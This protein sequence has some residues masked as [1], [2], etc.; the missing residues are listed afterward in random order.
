[1]PTE[2]LCDRDRN[3]RSH[4]LKTPHPAAIIPRNQKQAQAFILKLLSSKQQERGHAATSRSQ[5]GT[6]VRAVHGAAYAKRSAQMPAQRT[7]AAGR[8]DRHRLFGLLVYVLYHKYCTTKT[9]AR[10][11]WISMRLGIHFL[12]AYFEPPQ[13]AATCPRI[14]N[15][16]LRSF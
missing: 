16:R 5:C 6:S 4:P 9:C 14:Q 11:H 12:V 8:A 15:E 1:M 3:S 2:F 7:C 13:S 10:R